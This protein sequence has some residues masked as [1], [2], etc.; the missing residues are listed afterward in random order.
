MNREEPEPD[1]RDLATTVAPSDKTAKETKGTPTDA[2]TN[3]APE[4]WL[5]PIGSYERKLTT[6]V[7]GGR[8]G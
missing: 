1:D 4:R 8:F 5:K 2:A 7:E 3:V 6:S